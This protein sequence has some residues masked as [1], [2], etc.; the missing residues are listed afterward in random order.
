ML[1]ADFLEQWIK[2][3]RELRE[4]P[5]TK[6]R[7]RRVTPMQSPR[8]RR[9]M[10][11]TPDSTRAIYN[12]ERPGNQT[13]IRVTEAGLSKEVGPGDEHNKEGDYRTG[14]AT[15]TRTPKKRKKK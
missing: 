13:P 14:K 12:P 5:P 7:Q 8:M 2:K 11:Q 4:A 10:R 15:D 6:R 1:E 3:Q 9:V